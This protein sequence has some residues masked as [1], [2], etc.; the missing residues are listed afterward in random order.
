MY[1]IQEC[2]F[3]TWLAC[4][5]LTLNSHNCAFVFYSF[6]ILF[7]F[8]WLKSACKERQKYSCISLAEKRE[9]RTLSFSMRGC[10]GIDHS[11]FFKIEEIIIKFNIEKKLGKHPGLMVKYLRQRLVLQTD[12]FCKHLM[13]IW[14]LPIL[15]NGNSFKNDR[16]YMRGEEGEVMRYRHIGRNIQDTPS[17]LWLLLHI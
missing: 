5:G 9:R 4:K 8:F 1:C 11:D 3:P 10:Q 13:Y 17:V 16:K 6:L 15:G 12:T 14:G 2:A 7:P